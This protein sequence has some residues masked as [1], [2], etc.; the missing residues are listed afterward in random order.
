MGELTPV[1]SEATRLIAEHFGQLTAESET[2]LFPHVEIPDPD[3]IIAAHVSAEVR[4]LETVARKQAYLLCDA[5]YNFPGMGKMQHNSTP[6]VAIRNSPQVASGYGRLPHA[7]IAVHASE[8]ATLLAIH[9]EP[10]VWLAYDPTYDQFAYTEFGSSELH[11]AYI[12]MAGCMA[13]RMQVMQPDGTNDNL[14]IKYWDTLLDQFEG[15]LGSDEASLYRQAA[16]TEM[17]QYCR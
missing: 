7:R 14:F 6:M 2:L 9:R 1:R 11:K 16:L 10:T 8:V 4:M 3:G 5:M 13:L 12:P 15:I 17:S